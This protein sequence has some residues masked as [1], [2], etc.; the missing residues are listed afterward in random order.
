MMWGLFG[1]AEVMDC[2]WKHVK[3]IGRFCNRILQ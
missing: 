2:F 1:G 3:E